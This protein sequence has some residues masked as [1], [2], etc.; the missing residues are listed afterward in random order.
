MDILNEISQAMQK[1]RAKLVRELV[2][3]GQE[4][5]TSAKQILEEGLLAGMTSWAINFKTMRFLSPRC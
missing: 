5:G 1:G 3:N 2:P 4:E